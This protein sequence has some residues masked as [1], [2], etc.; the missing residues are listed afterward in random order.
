MGR[1]KTDNYLLP[2]ENAID[3]RLTFS[4]KTILTRTSTFLL[5]ASILLTA[6][7]TTDPNDRNTG[8]RRGA[9]TGA[10]LGLTM[11]AMTGEAKYAAAGA[12]AGGVAGGAA[13]NWSDYQNERDDYRTETLA[14]AIASKDSGGEGEAPEGWDEI[15]SFIGTWQVSIWGLDDEGTRVDGTAMATSSLNTTESITFKF[16]DLKSDAISESDFGTSTLSFSSDRGFELVNHFVTSP[17]GNRYVGHYDNANGKYIFFYAGTDNE[18]FSGVKRTDWRMEMKMVGGDV[19]IFETW[20]N[21][22]GQDK[23]IHSY[24]L[25]RKS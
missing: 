19:I 21:V 5:A 9:T 13:G 1:K 25:V 24:R 6:C 2:V 10:I 14:A 16:T 15:N 12:V 3:R 22:G 23:Q 11:G 7:K 17:E 20:A 18:T 4:M 8:T